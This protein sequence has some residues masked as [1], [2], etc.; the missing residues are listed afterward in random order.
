ML[1]SDSFARLYVTIDRDGNLYYTVPEHSN[2]IM[3]KEHNPDVIYVTPQMNPFVARVTVARDS[4]ERLVFNK[5]HAAAFLFLCKLDN[6]F[7]DK[8]GVSEQVVFTEAGTVI[9]KDGN[10]VSLQN[11]LS[12]ENVEVKYRMNKNRLLT[13][14]R[15]ND[16]FQMMAEF[17]SCCN[18]QES[19]WMFPRD[20]DVFKFKDVTYHTYENLVIP[21]IKLTHPTGTEQLEMMLGTLR[22]SSIAYPTY[23]AVIHDQVVES[24]LAHSMKSTDGLNFFYCDVSHVYKP[25]FVLQ[26]LTDGTGMLYNTVVMSVIG[27]T[28]LCWKYD[29]EEESLTISNLFARTGSTQITI[30]R[31]QADPILVND[32]TYMPT[33]VIPFKL[34]TDIPYMEIAT[35][36]HAYTAT[37]HMLLDT[38]R[39]DTTIANAI[40][41]FEN[42][43]MSPPPPKSQVTLQTTLAPIVNQFANE[44]FL[45]GPSSSVKTD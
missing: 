28:Q 15:L 41:D 14:R 11:M 12:L 4:T 42:L 44:P 35:E 19:V 7:P 5:I 37:R 17:L 24:I 32:P 20:T 31:K 6:R 8:Y 43:K 30:Y 26:M 1:P 10:D 34:P 40:R 2:C 16:Y 23:V 25:V 22:S 29:C 39:G 9:T 36:E 3:K 38:Q 33:N 18:W 45:A 27:N 13:A 21:L